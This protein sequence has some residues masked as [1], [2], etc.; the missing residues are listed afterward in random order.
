MYILGI[1]EEVFGKF[2]RGTSCFSP[3]A[4]ASAPEKEPNSGFEKVPSFS[5]SF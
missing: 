2:V 3:Y 5:V 4:S 1:S